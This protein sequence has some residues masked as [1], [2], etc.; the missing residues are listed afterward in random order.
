D[1]LLQDAPFDFQACAVG[2]LIAGPLARSQIAT[3]QEQQGQISGTKDRR[4]WHDAYAH[5]PLNTLLRGSIGPTLLPGSAPR[6][7]PGT[8]PSSGPKRQGKAIPP[9]EWGALSS[10]R[11]GDE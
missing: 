7:C 2:L 1:H 6:L 8:R 4:A 5:S 11:A 3:C 9:E 10:A